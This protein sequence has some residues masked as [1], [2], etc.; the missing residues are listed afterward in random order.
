MKRL[1]VNGLTVSLILAAPGFGAPKSAQKGQAV[2]EGQVSIRIRDYAHANPLVRQHAEQVAG[3]ILQKAGVATRWIDCPVG[4]SGTGTCSRPLFNP[5]L[6]CEPATQTPC[7]IVCLPGGALGSA[8][9]GTAAISGPS[10]RFS[11]TSQ[12]GAP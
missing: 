6:L 3:E 11:T 5:G 10:H 4:S 1:L 8:I 2:S 12:R 7:P 9:E